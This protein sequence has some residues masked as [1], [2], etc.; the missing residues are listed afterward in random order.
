LYWHVLSIALEKPFLGR[1]KNHWLD[2][3]PSSVLVRAVPLKSVMGR[4]SG[5]YFYLC[6]QPILIMSSTP[7]PCYFNCHEC[8]A[9]NHI[10]PPSI[11]FRYAK[12]PPPPHNKNIVSLPPPRH[13]RL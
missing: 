3:Y 9:P 7:P 10:D 2:R 6:P 13:N 4:G 5:K 1:F 12:T 11:I 8:I